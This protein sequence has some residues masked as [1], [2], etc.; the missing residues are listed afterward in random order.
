MLLVKTM[1]RFSL[2]G[3]KVANDNIKTRYFF[4]IEESNKLKYTTPIKYRSRAL[5]LA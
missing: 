5:V 1:C 4:K 3:G 2:Y